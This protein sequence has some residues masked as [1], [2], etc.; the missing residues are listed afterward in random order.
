MY[1]CFSVLKR[2]QDDQEDDEDDSSLGC[3]STFKKEGNVKLVNN[4]LRLWKL[5]EI[6]NNAVGTF[7]TISSVQKKNLR[8]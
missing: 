8:K 7:F 5:W 2:F 4:L 3:P 1:V 6:E